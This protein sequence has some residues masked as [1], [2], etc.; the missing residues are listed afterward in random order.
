MNSSKPEVTRRSGQRPW[1]VTVCRTGMMCHT[2]RPDKAASV[3]ARTSVRID[4]MDPS[5]YTPT[6]VSVMMKVAN[7]IT[8]SQEGLPCTR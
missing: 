2:R 6:G 5:S 8:R 1:R 7:I 4:G 3:R